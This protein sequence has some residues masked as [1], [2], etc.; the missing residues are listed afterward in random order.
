MSW[1]TSY[2]D[3]ASEQ[4]SNPQESRTC[5]YFAQRG[6]ST[7]AHG[8]LVLLDQADAHFAHGILGVVCLPI[9]G[10]NQALDN[11]IEYRKKET[12]AQAFA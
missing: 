12:S 11:S 9:T 7:I 5:H 2:K 6:V 10:Q 4:D 1:E 8:L 3:S